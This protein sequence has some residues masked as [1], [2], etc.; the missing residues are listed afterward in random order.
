MMVFDVGARQTVDVDVLSPKG[1]AEGQDEFMLLKRAGGVRSLDE[2]CQGQRSG[3][4]LNHL[5]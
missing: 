1:P 3:T 2:S 4:V 5:H